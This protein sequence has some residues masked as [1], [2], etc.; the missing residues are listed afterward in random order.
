MKTKNEFS[1]TAVSLEPLRDEDL[2]A[3]AGGRDLVVVKRIDK[4]SP[5]LMRA[6]ASGTHLAEATLTVK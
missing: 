2:S 6:C 1:R 3:V 4:A 5:T